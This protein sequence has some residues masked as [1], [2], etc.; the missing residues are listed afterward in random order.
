MKKKNMTE[1]IRF[2]KNWMQKEVMKK[3][4]ILMMQNMEKIKTF[5]IFLTKKNQ[6]W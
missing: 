5:R 3:K 6:R 4:K 2:L 1:I